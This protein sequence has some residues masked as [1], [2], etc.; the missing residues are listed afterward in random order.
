MPAVAPPSPWE[1]VHAVDTLR[2]AGAVVVLGATGRAVRL[3]S[4]G[5]VAE[6]L[7]CSVR[8]VREHE[9][10]FPGRLKMPGGEVRIPL[11]DLEAACA[12]WRLVPESGPPARLPVAVPLAEEAA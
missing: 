11:R 7:S 5:E 10:E 9:T 6:M 8:W 4:R 1:I 12:R 3:F 2:Q